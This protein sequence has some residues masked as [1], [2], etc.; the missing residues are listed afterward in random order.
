ML[1]M[2]EV[3][4]DCKEPIGGDA[5]DNLVDNK[6]QCRSCFFKQHPEL[7]SKNRNCAKITFEGGIE[8]FSKLTS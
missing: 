1:K 8:A 3:C 4:D 5:I 7:S 6:T 2:I